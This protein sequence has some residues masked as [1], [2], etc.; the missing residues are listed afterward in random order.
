MAQKT[1]FLGLGCQK[2][3]T[4]WLHRYIARAPE[5]NPGFTKE[6]HIWDALDVPIMAY[7]RARLPRRLWGEWKMRHRMQKTP[8]FYFD[9]FCSLYSDKITMTG[10][11]SPSY[12][13][14][15]RARLDM[16]KATFAARD[17]ETKAL[18]LMRDPVRRIKS[19]V[20]FNLDRKNYNE[21]IPRGETDFE[22]ALAAY[23]KT[24]HATV[25]TRYQDVIA[26]AQDVFGPDHVYVGL[27]E[28]MFEPDEVKRVSTFCG[29][30]F[31]PE[32]AKVKVNKTKSTLAGDSAL[33]DEIRAHYDDVY[34]FAYER[35]PATKELWA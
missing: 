23:Y 9:Y 5:F 24:D 11:I 4:S 10:D 26:R 20:R 33:E 16:I 19:A 3:G 6:Y 21:G 27:Y 1:F 12:S 29:V 7:Y 14:L 15:S 8:A 28:N 31:A 22:R 34:A 18:I 32:F 2:A 30:P 35:Y 17:V 25:R 13:A